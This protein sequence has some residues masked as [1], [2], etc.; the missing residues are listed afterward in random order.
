MNMGT[1]K[2]VMMVCIASMEL[3]VRSA[4]DAPMVVHVNRVFLQAFPHASAMNSVSGKRC[5]LNVVMG[6]STKRAPMI[7]RGMP[8]MKNVMMG[9]N[10]RM[11]LP[12]S[13]LVIVRQPMR[14]V[15]EIREEHVNRSLIVPEGRDVF[16]QIPQMSVRHRRTMDVVCNASMSTAGTL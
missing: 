5:P 15:P 11:G 10:V 14:T 8:M 13:H 7:F 6:C 3:P 1:P 16:L 9:W 12:A 4:S 2:S